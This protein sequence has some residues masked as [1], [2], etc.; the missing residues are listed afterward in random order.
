MQITYKLQYSLSKTANQKV[1]FTVHDVPLLSAMMLPLLKCMEICTIRKSFTIRTVVGLCNLQERRLILQ[2]AWNV[3]NY[4]HGL[5][6]S[7]KPYLTVASV[8]EKISR[9]I[10]MVYN[11]L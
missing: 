6:W 4:F 1:L 7:P 8:A 5:L 3:N 9:Y 2:I 11:T 10:A